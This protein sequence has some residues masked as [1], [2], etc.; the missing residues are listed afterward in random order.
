MP[1]LHRLPTEAEWEY[2]ARAGTAQ[3]YAGTDAD[4]E[5]CRYANVLDQSANTP[6]QPQK[7]VVMTDMLRSRRCDVC[8]QMPGSSMT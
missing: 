5:I 2:A 4:D 1:G 3:R 6:A 8:S 7:F